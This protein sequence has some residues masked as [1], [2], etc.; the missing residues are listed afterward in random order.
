MENEK[1]KKTTVQGRELTESEQ[2][3]FH[4]LKFFQDPKYDDEKTPINLVKFFDREHFQEINGKKFPN[5]LPTQE[6]FCFEE[7]ISRETYNQW[8]KRHP[9]FKEAD[10]IAKLMQKDMLMSLALLGFYKEGFAKFTAVNITD[11]REKK[12]VIEDEIE[13]SKNKLKLSYNLEDKQE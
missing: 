5:V 6:R 7:G 11:M 13:E 2:R 4:Y 8:T 1:L 10:K 9:R 12:A 3:Q